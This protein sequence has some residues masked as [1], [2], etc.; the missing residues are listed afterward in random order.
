MLNPVA[1][2]STILITGYTLFTLRIHPQDTPSLHRFSSSLDALLR[3]VGRRGQSAYMFLDANI[4]LLNLSNNNGS[5]EY[6]DT[7]LNNGFIQ[8]I[9]KASRVHGST[10]SLI[11][12]IL[13]NNHQG[14]LI[15]G[16]IIDDTSDHFPTFI[17][18]H[19]PKKTKKAGTL[20]TRCFSNAN[21]Q[22]FKTALGSL[23]WN[24]L[25]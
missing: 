18:Y 21:I 25:F 14:E 12:H 5:I 10:F 2:Q 22:Q 3:D 24:P 1:N 15:T 23:S 13:T 16:T 8:T 9:M 17:S 20:E 19:Q 7:L 6:L 11:D 4:N